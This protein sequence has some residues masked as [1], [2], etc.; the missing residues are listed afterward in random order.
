MSFAGVPGESNRRRE[1]SGGFAGGAK[2]SH[3]RVAVLVRHL[4]VADDDVDGA[5]P[6]YVARLRS[7][8]HGDGPRAGLGEQHRQQLARVAVVVDDEN[9]S[10]REQPRD[11]GRGGDGGL[12]RRFFG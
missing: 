5:M 6:Q 7:R 3:E 1:G 4:D 10:P 12:N 9:G 2:R 11:G 8:R